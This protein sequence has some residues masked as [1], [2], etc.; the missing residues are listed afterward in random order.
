MAMEDD[1]MRYSNTSIISK[2]K[3]VW[4]R[5]R[6][7]C[8]SIGC[9]RV[10][11]ELSRVTWMLNEGILPCCRRS[12]CGGVLTRSGSRTPGAAEVGGFRISWC[13]RSGVGVC[14]GGSVA[15]KWEGKK[16]VGAY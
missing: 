9:K 13:R 7:L 10:H 8:W 12:T 3:R 5:C 15:Q 14:G 1:P 16:G 11:A 2:K 4:E 6:V